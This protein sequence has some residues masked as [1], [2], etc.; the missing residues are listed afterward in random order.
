V[1]ARTFAAVAAMRTEYISFKGGFRFYSLSAAG[2]RAAIH[3]YYRKGE[4]D[5]AICGLA[6]SV[7]ND[8]L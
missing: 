3:I 4:T 8:M 6:S 7:S 2:A 1:Y 5:A